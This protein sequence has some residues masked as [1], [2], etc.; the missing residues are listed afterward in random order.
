M[1]EFDIRTV[2]GEVLEARWDLPDVARRA[3][4]FC[5]PHPLHGGTMTAP[6]MVG[7]TRHLVDRD[8]AVLRFNFR[9]VGRSTG[10]HGDGAQ[11]IADVAAAVATADAAYPEIPL[12]IAGWSFGA[13]VALAWAA[14]AGS[15]HA[16]AGIAPPVM[17]GLT[18]PLPPAD[19]LTPAP[20]AFILG[21]RDQFVKVDELE[22]YAR[23]I[24][25]DLHVVPA[26]D[27]FFS[28]RE[29]RVAG[30]VA[31]ALSAPEIADNSTD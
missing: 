28:F 29:E 23:S 17:S 12:S 27:H 5:H 1:S 20:R 21:D 13:A 9:G 30:V 18:P 6:L 14:D 15:R 10:T 22:R 3:V 16:Y 7:V 24:G 8:F 25:A 11:E 26:S 4:V 31:K 19:S 2:V